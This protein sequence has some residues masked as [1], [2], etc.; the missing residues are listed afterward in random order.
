MTA[1]HTSNQ[2]PTLF[3]FQVVQMTASRRV[4][5]HHRRDGE[6]RSLV[7]QKHTKRNGLTFV[8][9]KST[10]LQSKER[11]QVGQVTLRRLSGIKNESP[12][13]SKTKCHILQQVCQ[14]V[15][16]LPSP[17]E[18][19]AEDTSPPG[20]VLLGRQA[21]YLA[22]ERRLSARNDQTAFCDGR[23]SKRIGD[24]APPDHLSTVI[25]CR[26]GPSLSLPARRL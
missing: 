1:F 15:A 25:G 6:V 23:L 20:T 16:A 3:K 5:N 21:R 17:E 26:R 18:V 12:N 14:T 7:C 11:K 4:E 22:V 13:V 8:V 2:G 24:G 10:K 9:T 19:T